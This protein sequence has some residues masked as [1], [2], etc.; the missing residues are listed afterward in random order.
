MLSGIDVGVSFF[1]PQDDW[2]NVSTDNETGFSN[3]PLI[4]AP[5]LRVSFGIGAFKSKKQ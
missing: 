5:Y 1:F 4:V 2:K 3:D